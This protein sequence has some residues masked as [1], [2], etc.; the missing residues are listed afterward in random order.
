MAVAKRPDLLKDGWLY[1]TLILLRSYDCHR[2][3]EKEFIMLQYKTYSN[4]ALVV[5]ETSS[6]AFDLP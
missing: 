3:H 6:K 1:Y 2:Y 4:A 5:D